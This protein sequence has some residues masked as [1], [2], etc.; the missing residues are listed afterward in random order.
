MTHPGTRV[1]GSTIDDETR[2]AHYSGPTDVIAIK[3]YCCGA[4]YPCHLCHEENAGHPATQWPVTMRDTPAV[5]CGVCG[6][7]L[8]IAR[9]LG[10]TGCPT[11]DAPFNPGCALHK[12]FY[13]EGP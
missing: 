12:H 4:Y 3:F 6:D 7:E 9:Y 1:H 8:T 2:C 10:V 11:C 13:F 5:L